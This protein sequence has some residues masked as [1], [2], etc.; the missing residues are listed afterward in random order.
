MPTQRARAADELLH[1]DE[2]DAQALRGLRRVYESSDDGS[3]SST[4]RALIWRA[5]LDAEGLASNLRELRRR[6]KV[7]VSEALDPRTG[8]PG[9]TQRERATEALAQIRVDD[10]VVAVLHEVRSEIIRDKSDGG[11]YDKTLSPQDFS[12]VGDVQECAQ[13][14]AKLLERATDAGLRQEGQRNSVEDKTQRRRVFAALM[15][16]EE[17]D[18]QALSEL[19]DALDQPDDGSLSRTE[20]VLLRQAT[21]DGESFAFGLR[22]ARRAPGAP[23]RSDLKHRVTY[24]CPGTFVDETETREVASWDVRAATM[25][26]LTV[27]ARYGARPYAFRFTTLD[28]PAPIMRGGRAFKADPVQ[29]AESP[30]HFLGARLLALSDLHRL[31]DEDD[32]RYGVIYKNAEHFGWAGVAETCTPFLHFAPFKDGDVNLDPATGEAI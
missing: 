16:L 6:L 13:K 17:P 9:R 25:V 3:L 2:P 1:I 23:P 27:D 19:R 11:V 20:L 5:M 21:V 30:M 32:G 28:A 18:A 14:L 8:M 29:V 24:Y 31:A 10:A 22:Y 12:L 15:R 7:S 26:A 4:E